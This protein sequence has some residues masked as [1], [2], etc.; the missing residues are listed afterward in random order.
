[1]KAIARSL[2]VILVA[3]IAVPALAVS[4]TIDDSRSATGHDGVDHGRHPALR[5]G[6]RTMTRLTSP[7][8]MNWAANDYIDPAI[9]SGAGHSRRRDLPGAIRPR[10]RHDDVRR[11]G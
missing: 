1:M 5:F 8:Y 7:G 9:R 10:L 2:V 3:L 11:L 6:A 4:V